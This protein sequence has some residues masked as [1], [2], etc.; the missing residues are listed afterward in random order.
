[1]NESIGQ[2]IRKIFNNT[3]YTILHHRY[4]PVVDDNSKS[5]NFVVLKYYINKSL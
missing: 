3:I 4:N 5:T 2:F 1:M